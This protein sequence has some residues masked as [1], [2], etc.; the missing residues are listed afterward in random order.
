[1]DGEMLEVSRAH[2]SLADA[3]LEL[4]MPICWT[5]S[6]VRTVSAQPSR[7]G[8]PGEDMNGL[9]KSGSQGHVRLCIFLNFHTQPEFRLTVLALQTRMVAHQAISIIIR[10]F[11]YA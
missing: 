3:S 8:W 7:A 10:A 4:L 5:C 2:Q 11:G 9:C 1:M 6:I